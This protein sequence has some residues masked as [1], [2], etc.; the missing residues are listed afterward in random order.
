MENSTNYRSDKNNITSVPYDNLSLIVAMTRSKVIGHHNTL[1]WH[2]PEDLK[3]FKEQTMGS[4][5]IMGR[6][7]F[8]SIGRPL[9]GR[10]NIVVTRNHDYKYNG[11]S[12][13]KYPMEASPKVD[14]VHSLD[15]A[16]EIA[17]KDP[18]VSQ[19]QR[20]PFLIG[21][22]EL[23]RLGLSKCRRLYITWIETE[24]EGNTYFPEFELDSYKLIKKTELESPFAHSYCVYDRQ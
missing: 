9:P 10:L 11:T 19:N 18:A 7:T 3:Y 6:K 23:F 14:I 22:A 2:L 5:I 1:P 13:G 4:P 24:F 16:I 12:N 8:E 17:H 21:G 20:S 15:K